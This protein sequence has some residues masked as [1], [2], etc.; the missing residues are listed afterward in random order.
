MSAPTAPRQRLRGTS[1]KQEY[2]GAA[3]ARKTGRTRA[4]SMSHDSSKFC[5]PEQDPKDAGKMTLVLTWTRPWSTHGRAHCTPA[6]A[7]TSSSRPVRSGVRWSSG[8]QGSGPTPRR[9][10]AT[11]TR[12]ESSSTAS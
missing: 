10:S 4:P 7:S 12:R 9:L 2:Q 6:L 8:R 5:L 11:S 3:A 1:F